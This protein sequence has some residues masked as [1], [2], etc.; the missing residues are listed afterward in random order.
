MVSDVA[1][2]SLHL[3][4]TPVH[5]ATNTGDFH[6][7]FR[8]PTFGSAGSLPG[9]STRREEGSFLVCLAYRGAGG[10]RDVALGVPGDGQTTTPPCAVST[11]E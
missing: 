7:L 2:L 4:V 10:E 5:D 9:P 6:A 11:R 3:G 8:T 1:S